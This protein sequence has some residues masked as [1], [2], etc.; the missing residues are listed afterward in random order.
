MKFIVYGPFTLECK[1]GL[2]D[3]SGAAKKRFWA[4]VE[5]SVPGLPDACGCYVFVVKA[6]RGALPW[7]VGLTTKRVFRAEATGSHQINHYN[8]PIAQKVGVKPQLFL[9]AKQT[10]TGR[11]AKP[12][13]NS[14]ADVEFLEKFMF[15]LGLNRNA[16]LRNSKNTKFLKQLVVPPI[17]NA[18][19]RRPTKPETA[20]KNAL[21]L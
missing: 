7:Y 13:S 14:H 4:A 19:R 18:P 10:P 5:E 15:S 21:G 11:F 12:S 3:S 20:F 6:K 9:L 8:P 2:V 16:N 1:Q 17:L